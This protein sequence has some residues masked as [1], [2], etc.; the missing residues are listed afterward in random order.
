MRSLFALFILFVFSGHAMAEQLITK[1]SPHSVAETVSKLTAAVEAAG[2]TVFAVVDHS[3]GAA[4]IGSEL[5]PST[6]VIFGNPKI[7]TPIM[8]NNIRAGL[9]LPMR[10]LVFED[11]RQ[12][13]VT[14]LDPEALKARYEIS[15]ADEVFGKVAGAL[16]KLTDAAVK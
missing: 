9:D 4:K 7:G 14:Y 1:S 15:G 10:V 13:K 11:A 16:N 12:T 3:A 5:A 8:Q 6:L 2:A